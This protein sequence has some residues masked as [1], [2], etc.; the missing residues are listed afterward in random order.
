MHISYF[1]PGTKLNFNVE[2]ITKNSKKVLK[3]YIFVSTNKN[4]KYIKEAIN[5]G[6]CL[7]ICKKRSLNN[8][9]LYNNNPKLE[10]IRLLQIFHGYKN[11]IYTVGITGTNGKTT[12]AYL[13]NSIFNTIDQ[14]CYIGTNGIMYLNKTIKTINTTPS[15]EI[16]YSV[17]QSLNKQNINNLVME[18]SSEA[19]LDDRVTNLDFNGAIFTNL[20]HEHL[21]T[22]KNMNNYFLCKTKLFK[23]LKY[24][25]LLVINADDDYSYR[26]PFYTKAR[27]ITYGFDYGDYQIKNYK[28]NLLGS[29]FEVMYKGKSLDI[30]NTKLFG[31][32][33]IYNI[34]SVIA[35]TYE[36]GIPLDII[37]KGIE[38][39][40]MVDGRFMMYE[41]NEITYVIDYAH[42]PEALKCL[43]ENVKKLA[44]RNIIL[45]T[46]AAGEKDYSKRSKMGIIATTYA[47]TT[48]FTSEDPKNESL[49]KIFSDL[50]KGIKD[51]DYYLTLSRKSAI[52]LAVNIAKPHD[53]VLITGKGNEDVEKIK[54][55]T[56]K[57]NDLQI[58][59]EALGINS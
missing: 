28:M 51:S 45:I 6:A 32:Y 34:L 46:G 9:F 30:F 19:I 29:S 18:V 8:L 55:Y 50:T 17:Y 44:D 49:F 10:Y 15:P 12:T 38:K 56:F 27:I 13:L 31:K 16:I 39:I 4:K 24:N 36:I 20:S 26:I 22:H 53:I 42:T 41:H 14:S 48:I 47:D 3:N 43:L 7:I 21:N 57:N 1:Y 33:N 54:N 40:D 59:K 37:K 2:G 58:L 11:N 23:S 25:D 52:K 35:Y 5:N